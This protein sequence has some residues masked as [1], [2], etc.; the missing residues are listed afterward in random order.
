MNAD[1]D[2]AMAILALPTEE[3]VPRRSAPISDVLVEESFWRWRLEMVERIAEELDPEKFGVANMYVFGST[4]NATAGPASD[5]D[6]LVHVNGDTS[7]LVLLRSWLEGWSQCL[8]ATNYLQTGYR[9]DGLLDVHIV[10][11]DDIKTR[12][13]WAAKINAVTDAARPLSL[14]AR[15]KET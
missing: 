15:A 7:Q 11:D 8:A 4:K 6:L 13:S 3:G 1:L 12:T 2:E 9:T 10:T 5:I 14:G